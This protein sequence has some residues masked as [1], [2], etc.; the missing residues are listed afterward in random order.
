[1][2]SGTILWPPPFR[3]SNRSKHSRIRL[4]YFSADFRDH[5]V[6]R[7]ISGLIEH[8]DRNRFELIGFALAKSKRDQVRLR[9]EKS[10]DRFFDVSTVSDNHVAAQARKLEIDIAID[11]TGFTEGSRTGIFAFRPAPIQVNYL[12]YAGTMGADY[13]DYLIADRTIIPE[14][15][16][17]YYTEKIAYLPHSYMPSSADTRVPER[18]FLRKQFDLPEGAFVFC[19]FNGAYKISPDMFDIW[20]RLLKRVENSVLWLGYNNDPVLQN[21]RSAAAA[22]GIGEERLVFTR[23]IPERDVH[24]SRL[25]LADLFLDTLPYNA[26]AT[27]S[28]A[29]C[30]C[31]P[32]LTCLGTTFPGRVAA[33][34]LNAAGLPELIAGTHGE[35]EAMAT[36][37]ALNP[38]QQLS[39]R[40]RLAQ[41]HATFPLFNPKLF[42]RNIESVYEAMLKRHEAGLGP[43]HID[44]SRDSSG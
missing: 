31:L 7:A 39:I 26:H 16:R 9:L 21:L 2:F 19:C 3:Y 22:R 38:Q 6:G 29:L 37:L 23:S 12:G 44:P 32:V 28:D 40:Q 42:A 1:M 18:S 43:D 41:N 35:Y 5:P 24:L 4:G 11:L 33:S 10:F 17:Q 34:L 13:I 14:E 15:H 30:A 27:A 8:H 25:T 20:M 36:R